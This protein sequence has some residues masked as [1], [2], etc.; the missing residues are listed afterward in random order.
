VTGPILTV[1]DDLIFLS[2]IQQTAHQVGVPVEPVDPSKAVE[3]IT[4]FLVHSIILD[5]NHR[6]GTAVELARTIKT[7]PATRHVK[8]MGFLS[9]VQSDLAAA[10]RAAGCDFVMPRSAFSQQLPQLL[11]QL[12]G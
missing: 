2:K 11:L 5:L 3:R 6:S 10:A 4:E 1:V 7:N 9:H 12:A 8:V